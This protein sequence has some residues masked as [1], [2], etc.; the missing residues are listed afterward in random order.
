[1]IFVWMVVNHCTKY[2]KWIWIILKG[3][4]HDFL[5]QKQWRN[6]GGAECPEYF[7]MGNFCRPTGKR[8]AREKRKYVKEEGKCKKGRWERWKIKNGRR[9]SYKMSR[10]QFFIFPV[11]DLDI[12]PISIVM[13][14]AVLY[15]LTADGIRLGIDDLCSLILWL[16]YLL[17]CRI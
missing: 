16:S 6:K 9:K 5:C 1:M 7:W 11:K 3:T 12:V 10:G 8:E 15:S 17:V 2:C 13:S 14:F 4:D